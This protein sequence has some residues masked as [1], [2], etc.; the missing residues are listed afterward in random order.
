MISN[1]VAR[2]R[3]AKSSI[4]HLPETASRDSGFFLSFQRLERMGGLFGVYRQ[5]RIPWFKDEAACTR[6][7]RGRQ[8]CRS[9]QE[10]ETA[11][12]T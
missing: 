4:S 7:G 12:I 8:R 10:F 3:S 9:D 2:T 11:K 5:F 6:L 1:L